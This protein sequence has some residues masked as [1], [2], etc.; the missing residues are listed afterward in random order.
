MPQFL[1]GGQT[2]VRAVAVAQT[3]ALHAAFLECSDAAARSP[4]WW[5]AWKRTPAH[6]AVQLVAAQPA[7]AALIFGA[8]SPAELDRARAATPPCGKKSSHRRQ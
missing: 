1:V 8:C 3:P 4:S 7:I 6:A 5:R 2:A